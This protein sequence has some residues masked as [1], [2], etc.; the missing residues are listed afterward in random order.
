LQADIV[1]T[2]SW[3]EQVRQENPILG[4]PESLATTVDSL[5]NLQEPVLE[6]QANLATTIDTLVILQDLHEPI[7]TTLAVNSSQEKVHHLSFASS[8]PCTILI[9]CLLFRA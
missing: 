4:T 6:T 5:V 8:F 2:P 9:F 3:E 7:V 1:H